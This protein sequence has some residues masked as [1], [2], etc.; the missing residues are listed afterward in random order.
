MTVEFIYD[1][2]CPHVNTARANLLQAFGAAHVEVKWTEWERS[3]SDAPLHARSFGSPA[4][5]VNGRDV[6][7]ELPRKA[8]D[9]CRLYRAADGGQTGAPPAKTIERALLSAGG[10]DRSTWT[11]S[12]A[13][14]SGIMVALLPKLSCP[15]CWPAYAGLLTTLG[16]GF[17]LSGRYLFGV[18]AAFLVISVAALAFRNRER[19]GIAPALVGLAGAAVVLFGKFQFDSINSTYAGLAILISASLWNSWPQR[20][21]EPCPQCAP[22]GDDLIQLSAKGR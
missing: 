19:R 16:L 22:R 6:A 21:T 18:T 4:V 20:S 11:K 9:Y 10:P 17:L 12:L 14:A 5:L 13:V 2:N 15:M 3:S 1:S 7:G 8:A